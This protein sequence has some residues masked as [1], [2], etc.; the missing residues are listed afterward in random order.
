MRKWSLGEQAMEEFLVGIKQKE[1]IFLT[2]PGEGM[3]FEDIGEPTKGTLTL[4]KNTWGSVSYTHLHRTS[5]SCLPLLCLCLQLQIFYD[6]FLPKPK[7]I[8]AIQIMVRIRQ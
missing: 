5:R 2:L 1:C 8:Q 7:V 6:F 3:L 4:M